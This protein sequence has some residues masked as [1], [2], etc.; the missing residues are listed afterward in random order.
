V[1]A[2]TV[3]KSGRIVGALG[4][5]A[6]V[7]LSACGATRTYSG[8]A[9]SPNEV[10]IIENPGTNILV[11]RLD[12]VYV[13]YRCPLEVLPGAHT[14]TVSIYAHWAYSIGSRPTITFTA[15]AG[16]TYILQ[17]RLLDGQ[18]WCANLTDKNGEHSYGCR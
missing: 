10:A 9:R 16:H 8:P 6:A 15:E 18:K 13:G 14:F 7:V 17:T 1:R 5:L 11:E 4:M 12:G 2:A 3:G